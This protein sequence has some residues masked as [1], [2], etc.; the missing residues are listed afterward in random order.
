MRKYLLLFLFVVQIYNFQCVE[1]VNIYNDSEKNDSLMVTTQDIA[2]PKNIPTNLIL[3][4]QSKEII[5][6]YDKTIILKGTLSCQPVNIKDV[7]TT[8]IVEQKIKLSFKNKTILKA[9]IFGSSDALAAETKGEAQ[10]RFPIV[11][12]THGMSNNLRNNAIYDRK[13]DWMLEFPENTII[14]SFKNTDGSKYFEIYFEGKEIDI[15]YRPLFY[16]K[17][18]NLPHF[19]PW[20]YNIKKESIT[21][22]CSWWAYFRTFNEENCDDL[23]KVWEEKK[24]AD[25]G[26]NFIQIDDVF[27]GEYDRDRENCSL[28]NSYHGGRPTTW[29]DWKKDIFP[30]GL[31]NYTNSVK[32]AGF[33]PGIWIGSY[34]S[35]V[36]TVKM[37]PD[38]FV[39]NEKNNPSQAP[40]VS[41][42]INASNTEAANALIRPTFRGIKNAGIEYVKIDLLR[43]FLYD[44]LH[45]NLDWL[46]QN[47]LKPDELLRSYLQIAREELGENTFIL[48]CWGVLPETIGLVDACRIGGDGYGPTTLQQY[49][50]WNGIVWRNDPDHCDI[51]PDKIANETG[52][53][54]KLKS[55]DFCK[56]ELIIRPALASIAGSMLLLSDKPDVYKNEDNLIG[57][58][59]SAPVLFSV[60]GQLYDYDSKKT[61]WLKSHER[62][63]IKSGKN[64]SAIDA[65]QF[66]E[67]S[68]YWL[69]EFNTD[70][71]NWFVLHRL[72][73]SEK[74]KDVLKSDKIKFKDLGLNPTKDYIVYEFWS[75]K[76][77]GVK[78][79]QF[80]VRE[81][82]LYGISSYSIREKLDRP[83]LISTNRHISQGAA[84]IQKLI[85]IDNT[86]QGR[87]KVIENDTYILT[88]YKP[89]NY[90][91]KNIE[92]DDVEIKTETISNILK[93]SWAPKQTES[94]KWQINFEKVE[95]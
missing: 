39:K 23:L 71:E 28:A 66:G 46:K 59:R 44:N 15:I 3:K 58:R 4:K 24:F 68:Q 19:K 25:Y 1:A 85:W 79:G 32:K 9:K 36:Q 87:S 89:D 72:N 74:N 17:H 95:K 26:Y 33:K 13:F 56:N 78:K 31:N 52:N 69:N 54:K 60:P 10:K 65:D 30:G 16:Q 90:K 75:D 11:R 70:F 77:I 76:F 88:I 62:V 35:D 63:E 51:L 2:H 48:A 34:F 81:L 83:Q 45:N 8:N 22:W 57:I 5:L 93:I 42:A 61:D 41:Y 38:W 43:H 94:I 53:V 50:S 21:G 64:P 86:L 84:E 47:N 91:L 82:D 92:I 18:K 40:W 7:S 67:V 73:W 27:Q 49:N 80:N 14:H 6:Q 20:T 29:L 12:T 55:N 37:N